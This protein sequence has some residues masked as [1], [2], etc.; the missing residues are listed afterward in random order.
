MPP[1]KPSVEPQMEPSGAGATEYSPALMRRSFAGSAGWFGS[2]YSSR[3]PFPFASTT[4]AVQPC[5]F[6]SSPVWSNIFVFSQPTTGPPPLVQSVLLASSANI[7]WCVEKQVPTWVSFFVLG[8]YTARSRP[9]RSTG[10]TF[11][12][13][14]DEPCLQTGGLSNGRTAAVSHTRPFSSS[15]GLW[16]FVLLV[17][18]GS[19]PQYGDV[20]PGCVP[21]AIGVLG[22]RGPIGTLLATC[23]T[24]SSTGM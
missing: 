17:Q 18:I 10:N 6:S 4:S 12:D 13:G 8:S 1:G 24:G 16:T 15:I 14:C 9:E 20:A 22:S 5:D 19:S 21:A 3:F 23:R 2:V 7:R 11:A